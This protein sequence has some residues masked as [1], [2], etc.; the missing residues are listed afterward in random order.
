ME[1]A[2]PADRVPAD[3]TSTDGPGPADARAELDGP[4]AETPA[5]ATDRMPSSGEP[6]LVEPA[7]AARQDPPEA[8]RPEPSVTASREPAASPVAAASR[9][10]DRSPK[11]M[12]ISLLV[13]L[14]PI[15]LLLAFYRGFLGGDQPTPV[16]PTPAVEQA[17]AAKSFPVSQPAGL[18]EEW[19][20]VNARYQTVE[21]GSTLRIGYV[22]PEGKGAQLL[23][24]S[25]PAER[26]IPTELTDRAQPQGQTELAGRNWQRYTAR[27]NEQA[28]VLLEPGRTVIVVGDARENELREL[29]GSLR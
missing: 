15:A 24:S 9:R 1:P 6:A 8:G 4:P 11:D 14:I 17:Q 29:A 2:Q 3:R 16:D 10:S 22:T 7:G 13:L 26:I 21:G 27:A 12:A 28:L 25:V 20:T 23:Q 5:D 18:G 19:R